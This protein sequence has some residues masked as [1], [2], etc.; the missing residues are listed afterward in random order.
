[1]ND[2]QERQE[3]EAPKQIIALGSHARRVTIF[4]SAA[5][6]QE[7]GLQGNEGTIRLLTM[8]LSLVHC[9]VPPN[10]KYTSLSD[11][12]TVA[13]QFA[14]A[15]WHNPRQANNPGFTSFRFPVIT[16]SDAQCNFLWFHL[17]SIS[18]SR[19]YHVRVCKTKMLVYTVILLIRSLSMV[20]YIWEDKL[21]IWISLLHLFCFRCIAGSRL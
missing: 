9:I 12:D 15:A 13:D 16:S 10:A 11:I 20:L 7:I 2:E 8:K 3:Q 1:M 21:D 4:K 19:V 6:A 14:A 5:A 17:C 18:D